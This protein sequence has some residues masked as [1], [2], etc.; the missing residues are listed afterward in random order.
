MLA[1]VALASLLSQGCLAAGVALLGMAV[2]TATKTGVSY[3]MDSRAQKT[4]TAPVGLVKAGLLVALQELEFP[5][6]SQEEVDEGE[7]IVAK[8]NDREVEIDLEVVTPRA[9]K[10][11][12][13]VH[14]GWFWKDRATAEEI[15]EQTGRGVEEAVMV[16]RPRRE[17][18]PSAASPGFLLGSSSRLRLWDP[19]V[20]ISKREQFGLLPARDFPDRAGAE[21]GLR[22]GDGL[23]EPAGLGGPRREAALVPLPGTRPVEPRGHDRPESPRPEPGPALEDDASE[24]SEAPPEVEHPTDQAELFAALDRLEHGETPPPGQEEAEAPSGLF[25]ERVGGP[26]LEGEGTAGR[27]PGEAAPPL[28]LAEG[29]GN[30]ALDLLEDP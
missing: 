17:G 4:F 11:R 6:A 23:Q 28:V 20:A 12:V 26:S 29:P 19:S 13:V 10:L 24:P 5:I 27:S 15:I 8:A 14:Q 2:S 21:P 1:A 25:D 7:R 3:T 22:A 16:A 30:C 18:G 9:T